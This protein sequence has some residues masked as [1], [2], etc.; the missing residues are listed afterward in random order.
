VT[1]HAVDYI[2]AMTGDDDHRNVGTLT[3]IAQ[4]IQPVF[5]VKP[6]VQNDEVWRTRFELRRHVPPAGRAVHGH[7]LVNQVI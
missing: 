7:V 1:D 6:K 5:A 4:E 2:L 3:N